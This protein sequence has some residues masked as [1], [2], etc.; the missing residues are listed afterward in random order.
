M[1]QDRFDD[2]GKTER[3]ED[4]GFLGDESEDDMFQ[5]LDSGDDNEDAPSEDVRW[6][7]SEQSSLF[8]TDEQT[9]D[10]EE[11]LFGG[12]DDDDDDAAGFLD[13]LDDDDEEE[14]V[15]EP[16]EESEDVERADIKNPNYDPEVFFHSSEHMEELED[17]SVHLVVTSP[18]YN[19]D[20]AYGSHDDQMN[21]QKE[22]LPMLARVF[23]ECYR[24]LAPGGRLV[25]NVPTLLRGGSSGGQAILADIDTMLNAKVPLWQ[26]NSTMFDGDEREEYGAL[27]RCINETDFVHREWVIWNKGFNDAGMAPNGSFPRPWG[28]LL[29]NMHEG[30]SVYQKP[31]KRD[32][33]TISDERI[34]ESKINKWADDICDDVWDISPE[35]HEF[36]YAEDEDV[37]PF[38]EE[39]VERAVTLW[40]Y[41]D[42]VVLDPFFGRGTTGKVAKQKERHSVGY[43]IRE[44]LE[45]D[46]E[47][48]VGMGQMML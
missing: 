44:A 40:T 29:N 37:P 16:E 24:V 25:V 39:L 45:E 11:S 3:D 7:D 28:I 27:K 5:G 42:D 21:Y 35:D 33:S 10:E 26:P 47:S 36:R 4:D 22:Y 43:E 48:Y 1:T 46:I 20:W 38:P 6:E 13:D 19:A 9:D 8:D 12:L 15:W 41:K 31:G 2:F 32:V 14:E 30:I 23:T 18:P 17:E 34:E